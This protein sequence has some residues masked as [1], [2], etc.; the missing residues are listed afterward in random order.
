[1][2]PRRTAMAQSMPVSEHL[3]TSC[4]N[5]KSTLLGN[6]PTRLASSVVPGKDMSQPIMPH[7]PAGLSSGGSKLVLSGPQPNRNSSQIGKLLFPGIE[8]QMVE[9]TTVSPR[10]C[11]ALGL[12][13]YQ[14]QHE[15]MGVDRAQFPARP[16]ELGGILEKSP[17]PHG[18]QNFGNTCYM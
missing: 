1:M 4:P 10:S 5:G 2:N 15:I 17:G 13:D 7:R 11:E 3:K 18:L 14:D 12:S 16:K 9:S 8:P 6:D